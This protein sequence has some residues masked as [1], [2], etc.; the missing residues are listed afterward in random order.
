MKYRFYL[1]V[2]VMSQNNNFPCVNETSLTSSD[3]LNNSNDDCK[4]IDDI[5]V[6]NDNG[7]ANFDT[8]QNSEVNH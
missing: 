5:A 7:W 1:Y 3:K 2:D 6:V 8:N 4:S